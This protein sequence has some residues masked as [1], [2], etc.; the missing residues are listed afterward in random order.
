MSDL[1]R[2]SNQT[3]EE[4]LAAGHELVRIGP[5]LDKTTRD[6]NQNFLGRFCEE[7]CGEQLGPWF[8]SC[9][10]ARPTES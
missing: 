7:Q 3:V 1:E 5:V 9:C 6:A 2:C 4:C 8:R 10:G